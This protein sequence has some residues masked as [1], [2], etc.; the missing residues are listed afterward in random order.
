MEEKQKEEK[1]SL[2]GYTR[3]FK[4]T[5]S[6]FDGQFKEPKASFKKKKTPVCFKAIHNNPEDRTRYSWHKVQDKSMSLSKLAKK[7]KGKKILE[8]KG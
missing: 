6:L 2:K 5:S 7:I 1:F 8:E 3:V 4:D